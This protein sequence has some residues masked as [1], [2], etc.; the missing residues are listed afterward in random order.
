MIE[1]RQCS[2]IGLVI[3]KILLCRFAGLV[4]TD[5]GAGLRSS[6]VRILSEM[7][8]ARVRDSCDEALYH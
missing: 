1:E 2:L 4:K 3:D 5:N 7:P 6:C 8:S